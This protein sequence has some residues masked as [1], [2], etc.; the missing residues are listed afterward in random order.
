MAGGNVKFFS[1]TTVF[2]AICAILF[3]AL[4]VTSL[5][6]YTAQK[7][8]VHHM[9]QK[10][11]AGN[12]EIMKVPEMIGKL[13]TAHTES[14]FLQSDLADLTESNEELTSELE[15]VQ[16]ELT[17]A[18][19]AK[20]VL[21][22]DKAGYTKNLIEARET[23]EELR[24]QLS[25]NDGGMSL[26]DDDDS[27][28]SLSHKVEELEEDLQIT[29]DAGASDEADDTSPDIKVSAGD[30]H[31]DLNETLELIRN[32]I[33]SSQFSYTQVE[34]NFLSRKLSTLINQAKGQVSESPELLKLLDELSG[35][36]SS[37]SSDIEE[38]LASLDHLK[39]KL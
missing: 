39:T 12:K 32:I 29:E 38:V 21:E 19:I 16:E 11:L 20:A 18:T 35:K 2:F 5:Q 13:R 34:R 33:L 7:E 36:A 8:R 28:E 22:A 23:V 17:L 15:E 6:K 26:Y 1:I 10:I 3:F 30:V 27:T 24:N 9:E 37:F 31:G 4:S 25:T 14:L